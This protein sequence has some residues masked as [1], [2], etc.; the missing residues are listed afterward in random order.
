MYLWHFIPEDDPRASSAPLVDVLPSDD[1]CQPGDLYRVRVND[2]TFWTF[3]RAE[4]DID[5]PE[6]APVGAQLGW[7][8]LTYLPGTKQHALFAA[9]RDFIRLADD[10]LREVHGYNFPEPPHL[11]RHPAAISIAVEA[12]LAV[13][14]TTSA[15]ENGADL[16]SVLAVLD[17]HWSHPA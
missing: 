12:M 17:E 11:G 8:L 7:R 9:A 14:Y 13:L 16:A 6:A 5:D 10:A 4:T 2:D 3:E 1:E 15:A